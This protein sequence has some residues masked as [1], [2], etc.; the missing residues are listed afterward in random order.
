[1]SVAGSRFCSMTTEPPGLPHPLIF[2]EPGELI[3]L[4][5]QLIDREPVEYPA[6][7]FDSH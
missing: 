7:W 2:G 6:W 4:L 5:V 3:E 1:M